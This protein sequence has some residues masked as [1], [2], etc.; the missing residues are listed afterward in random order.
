MIHTLSSTDILARLRRQ[1]W[2]RVHRKGSHVK[3]RHPDRGGIV[4]VPHLS[5]IHI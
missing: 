2:V 3:L 4:I 5:L 1:G